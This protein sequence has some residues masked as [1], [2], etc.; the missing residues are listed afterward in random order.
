MD[1]D[2]LDMLSALSDAGAEYLVVG[3]HAV[4]VHGSPRATGD[5]DLWIKPSPEN[6]DRVWRALAQ[7]GAPLG[8]LTREDLTSPDVVF[9]IGVQPLRIDIL[10]S[11]TGVI[12]EEAWPRRT[13]VEV[14]SRSIP[15]LSRADLIRNKR[16]TGRP[17]DAFDVESLEKSGE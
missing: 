15:F 13:L 17:K 2:F 3:A 11:I 4:A 12:F 9:Q 1:R 16:A 14:E 7:F 10:T 6:A 8:D 5:L